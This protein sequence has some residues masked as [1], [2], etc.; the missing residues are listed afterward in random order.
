MMDRRTY[1]KT[2]AAAAA[3]PI[4]RLRA[5]T[6]PALVKA[7]QAVLDAMPIAEADP[8]R[9]VYHFHPPANWTNDPNGT[10]YYRGWHHLF[11]QLNPFAARLG[12]QHWGHARSRD[13]VNWEHL[14]IAIWPSTEKGERAIFSGGAAIATDGRP[15]LIYT[16][17]GQPQ[18]EQWMAIPTTA[19]DIGV[20]YGSPKLYHQVVRTADDT[21][22]KY[23]QILDHVKESIASGKYTAGQKLPSEHELLKTF[24][25]SRVTVN[26][27]LRELQL[28]GLIERRA[29]SGSYVSASSSKGYTFGLLIPELGRTE[30][31]EPICRGMAEAKETGHHA[32][33]W[34]KSLTDSGNEGVDVE[35][36]CRQLTSKQL[37]GVF[38]APLELTPEKD[39]I[40]RTIAEKFERAGIPIVLLDRDLVAYP[41]RSQ[42]DLVGIDNRR[43][44]YV[45]TE[46]LISA[47]AKRPVFVGRPG[48]APTVDARIAGFREAILDCGLEF[49]PGTVRR[50]DP[51]DVSVVQRMV[52]ETRTD[53][54]V[55]A[56][57][58]TAAHV[59]KALLELKIPVPGRIRM[60]G[61]D[62]VK[63]STLLPVPLTTIHQ[64]CSE[65][66]ATAIETMVH[67][68]EH[69]QF[70]GREIALNFKLVVR[71]SS[72]TTARAPEPS[73]DNHG[74]I[75]SK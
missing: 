57:D 69:P 46:H 18:P 58:F 49:K 68:L 56:N 70:P 51:F 64:P 36:L 23:R 52:K 19:Y 27:A 62:D 4:G 3:A 59:M 22:P 7:T 25:T 5:E 12:S 29:G 65:I 61:I 31:F 10:I 24:G 43:A 47:G 39:A 55:C 28:T 45:I 37:S 44:G 9:P 72:G 33:L 63:Y 2:L 60:A 75:P 14:P 50:I 74:T 21:T 54:I 1:L 71:R 15:R 66:G 11:Y 42:Y 34:G 40:N 20:E 17:I 30:I 8:D 53:A 38:F 13:L 41:N 35:S 67:R 6:D 48:S 73:A 16:S 26:R 32:L